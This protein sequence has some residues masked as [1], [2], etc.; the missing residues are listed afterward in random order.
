MRFKA[1][2]Y[3]FIATAGFDALHSHAHFAWIRTAALWLGIASGIMM[4]RC[5]W[6]YARAVRRN[7]EPPRA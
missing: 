6:L 3:S 1:L 7:P 5:G 2:V 4:L